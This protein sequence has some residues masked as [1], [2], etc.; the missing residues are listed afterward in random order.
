MSI[1]DRFTGTKR[2]NK[3]TFREIKYDKILSKQQNMILESALAA[4]EALK[5]E[6]KSL[7]QVLFDQDDLYRELG[8]APIEVNQGSPSPLSTPTGEFNTADLIANIA[9]GIDASKVPGGKIAL[10]A[11]SE[12]IVSNSQEVNALGS[13]YMQQAIPKKEVE[14]QVVN[15]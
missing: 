3:R 13:H 14:K 1:L 15:Q 8:V 2:R 11:F 10:Q 5:M 6:V 9:K 7:R 12:F 4:N